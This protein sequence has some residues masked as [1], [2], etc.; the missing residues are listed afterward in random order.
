MQKIND[1]KSIGFSFT[2]ITLLNADAKN[3]L[4]NL[5]TSD[6]GSITFTVFELQVCTEMIKLKL[7]HFLSLYIT[8][9]S[10]LYRAYIYISIIFY[11]YSCFSYYFIHIYILY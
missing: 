10:T 4:N 2:D 1:A 8:L 9:K 3:D 11:L 5:A 6:L 7:P